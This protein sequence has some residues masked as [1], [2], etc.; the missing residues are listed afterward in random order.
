MIKDKLTDS[1]E[2]STTNVAGN[3]AYTINHAVLCFVTDF[4][5]PFVAAWSQHRFGKTVHTSWCN[6]SHHHAPEIPLTHTP[7]APPSEDMLK[8]LGMGGFGGFSDMIEKGGGTHSEPHVHTANCG[9]DHAGKVSLTASLKHWLV[10]EAVGDVGAVVV[11]LAAQKVAPEA[12]ATLSHGIERAVGGLYRASANRDAAGWAKTHGHTAYSQECAD[13]G[14]KLYRHE[15]DHL[16]QA[17]V[18]T[19]S[20]VALNIASQKLITRNPLPIPEMLL[21]KSLGAMTTAGILVGGRGLLPNLFNRLDN[22]TATRVFSPIAS[23]VTGDKPN[24]IVSSDDVQR[25][26]AVQEMQHPI[27]K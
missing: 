24:S 3:A 10:G 6:L 4:I 25:K 20:S 23:I 2:D 7:H 16:G 13:Y 17:A 27:V 1:T 19:V 21:Y 11:T 22:I 15:V 5:D 9:H 26:G 18:W 12:M 8:S 14:E